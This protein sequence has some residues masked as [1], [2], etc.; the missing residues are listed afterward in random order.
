MSNGS[1]NTWQN[2]SPDDKWVMKT[3]EKLVSIPS[4]DPSGQLKKLNYM[5]D[6]LRAQ[7]RDERTKYIAESK[8][9]WVKKLL[10]PDD[11]HERYVLLAGR[12]DPQRARFT[13]L[14]NSHADT[15]EHKDQE[16]DVLEWPDRYKLRVVGDRVFG[17]GID[18][19]QAA[20][21][22]NLWLALNMFPQ[23]GMCHLHAWDPDEE[24]N[25]TGAFELIKYLEQEKIRIHALLSSEVEPRSPHDVDERQS[26]VVTRYGVLKMHGRISLKERTHGSLAG[27]GAP[28]AMAEKRHFL[29]YLEEHFKPRED[30]DNPSVT[31]L[32]RRHPLLGSEFFVEAYESCDYRGEQTTPQHARLGY[33]VFLV[34][35]SDGEGDFSPQ[36]FKLSPAEEEEVTKERDPLLRQALRIQ[37][38]AVREV[39]RNREW[40][41]RG[42][43]GHLKKDKLRTSYPSYFTDP[44]HPLV[45]LI[46]EQ[47]Q[48]VCHPRL[49]VNIRGGRSNA[50]TNL[51]GAFLAKQAAEFGLSGD[52]VGVAV[53]IPYLGGGEHSKSEW[54]SIKSICQNRLIYVGLYESRFPEI[55]KK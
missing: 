20:A 46:A 42:I 33:K 1:E 8:R 31:R 29:N 24:A 25:S 49:A 52:N 34:P 11:S 38:Y 44:S 45:Q 51:Y 43:E 13:V 15:V 26:I 36:K 32:A 17:L 37:K 55:V 40:D 14:K 41:N 48:I 50:N 54:A 19:M 39:A 27:I 9:L 5:F 12:G 3:A 47:A 4:H 16:E 35:S 23:R 53:D 10:I 22:I 21:A 6:K 2:L 7:E 30:F 28:N 18:D